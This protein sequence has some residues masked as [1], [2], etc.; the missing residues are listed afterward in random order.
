MIIKLYDQT[1]DTRQIKKLHN[2]IKRLYDMKLK[3]NIKVKYCVEMTNDNFVIIDK[4]EYK[5]LR[6][7]LN[8]EN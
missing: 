1:I 7:I 2:D 6:K 8:N 4:Q 5:M 3:K